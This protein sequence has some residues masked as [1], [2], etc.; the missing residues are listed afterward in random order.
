MPPPNKGGW[1]CP[2][3][4]VLSGEKPPP[5]YDPGSSWNQR[6]M[7][8][9]EIPIEMLPLDFS[10]KSVGFCELGPLGTGFV[11]LDSTPGIAMSIGADP[12]GDALLW[13]LALQAGRSSLPFA[14]APLNNDSY[15][16][17]IAGG[18]LGIKAGVQ[19][20][21]PGKLAYDLGEAT[22]V[23]TSAGWIV[24]GQSG[25]VIALKASGVGAACAGAGYVGWHTGYALGQ[26]EFDGQTV[27]EFWG[28]QI[29]GLGKWLGIFD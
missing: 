15:L 10:S 5:D 29:Y 22:V 4:W 24:A 28:E 25:A 21:S 17:G 26:I 6:W 19:G 27:H 7:P 1:I 8:S 23:A 9:E 14:T 3:P 16:G 11:P 20:D 18:F 12:A 2:P 13:L